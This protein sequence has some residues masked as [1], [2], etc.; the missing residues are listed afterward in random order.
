MYAGSEMNTLYHLQLVSEACDSATTWQ[1][2]I[3]LRK[4]NQLLYLSNTTHIFVAWT[5]LHTRFNFQTAINRLCRGKKEN[6]TL[7]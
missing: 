1:K 6:K 2:T 7:S 4:Q 5:Q 3:A